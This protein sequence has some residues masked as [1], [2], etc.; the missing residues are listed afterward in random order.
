MR[1]LPKADRAFVLALV[2][3][4]VNA[5]IALA[6]IRFYSELLTPVQLGEIML[7]LGFFSLLEV[8]Y[9]A[10]L[11]QTAFF[12]SCRPN[13]QLEVFRLFANRWRIR[14]WG[15]LLVLVAT[16]TL[17]LLATNTPTYVG[18]W[19][20]VPLLLAVYLVVEPQRSSC[21]AILNASQFRGPYGVQLVA[22]SAL[23]LL[24]TL[25]AISL[26]PDVSSILWG[27]VTARTI[28]LLIA[29]AMVKRMVISKLDSAAQPADEKRISTTDFLHHCRP[30]VAMGAIGWASS[31]V[32]RYIIAWTGGMAAAG[33]YAVASGLMGRPYN[34]LGASLTTHFR[35]TLYTS[36]ASSDNKS[37]D[38]GQV[39]W[40]YS[41]LGIGLLGALVAWLLAE[42]MVHLLLAQ[43]YREPAMP[44]IP[45]L[46][47][48]L[49]AT[50][51]THAFDNRILANGRAR[52]LLAVQLACIPL[53]V[54]SLALGG[55]L[56][57]TVG[58]AWGR[59]AS[60]IVRLGAVMFFTIKTRNQ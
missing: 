9:S 10:S 15:P 1:T 59:V 47:L 25:L 56:G 22:D 6:T 60:E 5:I 38:Q 12:F 26:K 57:G 4:L 50:L 17:H 41:A 48:A 14:L 53:T 40:I 2:P 58:A 52:S 20:M 44:L 37:A 16:G 7:A 11:N 31:F 19:T 13:G 42:P 34:I 35:P 28:S 32:D 8:M 27:V 39:R 24:A 55:F 33:L 54:F 30:F 21:V 3:Q 23:M 45:I 51:V 36:S 18:A 29:R 46:G 43:E 49:T